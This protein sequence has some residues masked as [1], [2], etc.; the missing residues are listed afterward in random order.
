VSVS[1][2]CIQNKATDENRGKVRTDA[3]LSESIFNPHHRDSLQ[4]VV[5]R[6]LE[7]G[8]G[9]CHE[10]ASPLIR[11]WRSELTI[12]MSTGVEWP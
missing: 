1:K 7:S 10:R 3:R 8:S 5:W 11:T 4:V 6:F 12:P 9:G 2:G